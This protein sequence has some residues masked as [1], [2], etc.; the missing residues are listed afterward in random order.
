MY[1]RKSGRL[2]SDTNSRWSKTEVKGPAKIEKTLRQPY[3]SRRS[4]GFYRDVAVIAV[5][6][7]GM[8]NNTQTAAGGKTECVL[9]ARVYPLPVYPLEVPCYNKR[10]E[11]ILSHL[12]EGYRDGC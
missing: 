3:T 9:L 12:S 4:G 5:P 6:I 10:S 2:R 8:R 1:A 11:S 7:P